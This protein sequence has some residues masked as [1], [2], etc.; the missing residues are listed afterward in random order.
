MS[1]AADVLVVSSVSCI[2]DLHSFKVLRAVWGALGVGLHIVRG[3]RRPRAT[4]GVVTSTPW[5][6]YEVIL[7]QQAGAMPGRLGTKEML[8]FFP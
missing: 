2:R 7:R 3:F 6:Y 4:M 1:V 5:G 8:T